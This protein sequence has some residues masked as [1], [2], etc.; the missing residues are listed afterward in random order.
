[1]TVPSL[2]TIIQNLADALLGDAENFSQSGYRFALF[3][4]GTDFSIAFAFW[5]CTIGN[6]GL[7]EF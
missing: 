1:M 5:G 6:E 2:P 7:R 3:V 4:A